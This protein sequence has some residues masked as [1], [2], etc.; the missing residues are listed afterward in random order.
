M[1]SWR[2]MERGMKFLK[3]QIWG[4]SAWDLGVLKH[5]SPRRLQELGGS[6]T[7]LGCG[8]GSAYVYPHAACLVSGH[9]C[10][11]QAKWAWGVPRGS[12]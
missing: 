2:T 7:Q 1:K 4:V 11:M 9:L 5:W 6:I 8:P 10:E 3:P 12:G